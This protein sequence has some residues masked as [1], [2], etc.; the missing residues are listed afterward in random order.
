MNIDYTKVA[1]RIC[2]R[3]HFFCF[4]LAYR[5]KIAKKDKF[6]VLIKMAKIKQTKEE[7]NNT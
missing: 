4:D 5:Y 6:F 3:E 7:N 2:P 1:T